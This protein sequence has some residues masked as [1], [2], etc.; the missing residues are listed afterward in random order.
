[1]KAIIITKN[2]DKNKLLPIRILSTK[3]TQWN[4][5]RRYNY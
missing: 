2:T 3:R 1:M 5:F 4:N